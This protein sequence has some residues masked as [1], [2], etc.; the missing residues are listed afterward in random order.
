MRSCRSQADIHYIIRTHSSREVAHIHQILTIQLFARFAHTNRFLP[1]H[2]HQSENTVNYCPSFWPHAHIGDAALP[3]RNKCALRS[4]WP[5][6]NRARVVCASAFQFL[7]HGKYAT[8]VQPYK[9]CDGKLFFASR[10][11]KVAEMGTQKK[12]NRK[13]AQCDTWFVLQNRFTP[14]ISHTHHISEFGF[15][16][17][18]ILDL[19]SR[20][21]CW[22]ILQ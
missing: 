1:A 13:E 3:I 11:L 6:R 15:W 4:V 8:A 18:D 16:S 9:Y 14:C 22:I 21:V 5:K 10:Q 7:Q 20:G 12:W 19:I 2:I 17:L